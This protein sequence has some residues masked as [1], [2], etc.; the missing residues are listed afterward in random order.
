MPNSISLRID[1]Q[2][3]LLKQLTKA[4]LSLTHKITSTP[5]EASLLLWQIE[6]SGCLIDDV[7]TGTMQRILPERPRPNSAS[8]VDIAN[9]QRDHLGEYLH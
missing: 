1:E 7:S 4:L 9:S 2:R 6:A 8:L 3:Y 5:P